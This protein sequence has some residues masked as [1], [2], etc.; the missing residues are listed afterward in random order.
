MTADIGTILIAGVGSGILYHL[1]TFGVTDVVPQYFG[2]AA[3]VAAFYVLVVKGYEL[4]NPT[5]LLALRT[6]ISS[7]TTIWIGVF[8]F[9]SGAVFALKIGD[10]FSRGAILSFASLGLGL[11]LGE[12]FFYRALLRR[13]LERHRFTGRNV[14]LITDNSPPTDNAV[15]STLMTHGFQIHRQFMLPAEQQD[16][17]GQQRVICRCRRIFARFTNRRSYR[18]PR[19]E[20]FRRAQELLSALRALPLPVNFIPAGVAS[21]LLRR[22]SHALG[23]SVCVEMQRTPLDTFEQQAL[24]GL[25]TYSARL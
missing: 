20:T 19:S 14:I 22:P 21:D 5:E 24:S 16:K 7:V 3:V 18:P 25:L 1:E 12:Q 2:A 4:Y 9:L 15:V 11:L 23:N 8:L 13:G 17:K 10:E 6:Q